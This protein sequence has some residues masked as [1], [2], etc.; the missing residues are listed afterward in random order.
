MQ[1]G[2]KQYG[3]LEGN[4]MISLMWVKY[5]FLQLSVSN[6]CMKVVD[7]FLLIDDKMNESVNK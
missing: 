6:H 4:F 3:S 2:N 7:H 1:K 5:G